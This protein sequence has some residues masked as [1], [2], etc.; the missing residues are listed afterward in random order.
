[1]PYI[2]EIVRRGNSTARVKNYYANGLIVIYDINGEF[3]VGDTITFDES[4]ETLTLQSFAINDDF[5]LFYD[6]FDPPLD[7]TVTQD[8]GAFIVLDA[9]FTGLPSQDYQTT[10]RITVG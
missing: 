10:Y 1:M 7:I 9:H 8:D 2:N 4:G 3:Q 6:E 5:D